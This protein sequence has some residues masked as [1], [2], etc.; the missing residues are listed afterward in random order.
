MNNNIFIKDIQNTCILHIP[1]SS[2]HIPFYDWYIW[3]YKKEINKLTDWDT[4]KIFNVKI[5]KLIFK[6][7]RVFCDVERF[8][9]DDKEIMSKY[10]MWFF[11]TKSDEWLDLRENNLIIKNK[12]YEHYYKSHHNLLNKL[13]KEKLELYNIA[14]IIDCHSFSDIPFNRDLK[15]KL[16]RPDI[17]IW[18]DKFHTP[19]YLEKYFV[20]FFS[21]LGYSVRVNYPYSWSL[22]PLEYYN[23][24]K[25]VE[26]IMI[27][28]NRKLYMKNDIVIDKKV[29]KLNKIIESLFDF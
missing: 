24:N 15:Q 3:D 16:D 1:H 14:R 29:L 11:Y 28:I 17:C 9:K 12:V 6:Y 22:V 2:T 25:N 26:S 7:S 21:N 5:D 20:N 27:E 23:I 13:V 4:D 8:Y 10:W 19:K 18:V